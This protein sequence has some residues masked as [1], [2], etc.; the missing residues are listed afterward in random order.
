MMRIMLLLVV[1]LVALFFFWYRWSRWYIPVTY[2]L[3][4]L[5]PLL[6]VPPASWFAA[7]IF[8]FPNKK[9]S[10]NLTHILLFAILISWGAP[11]DVSAEGFEGASYPARCPPQVAG[12]DPPS[13]TGGK[14]LWTKTLG[15]HII[16]IWFS[17]NW[18]IRRSSVCWSGARMLCRLRR[19]RASR[20]SGGRGARWV[21]TLGEAMVPIRPDSKHSEW[22][23]VGINWAVDGYIEVWGKESEST[24]PPCRCE[25]WT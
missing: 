3:I 13:S 18:T 24:E 19:K 17:C 9:F 2:H 23:Y 6:V 11:R 15:N 10:F 4:S 25:L 14:L 12:Y 8:P 16:H 1:M 5:D 7:Q 22:G 21:L 20:R